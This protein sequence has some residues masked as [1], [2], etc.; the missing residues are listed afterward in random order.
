MCSA[1]GKLGLLSPHLHSSKYYTLQITV[2]I[3]ISSVFIILNNELFSPNVNV[4]AVIYRKLETIF[5]HENVINLKTRVCKELF[6]FQY[7]NSN[8]NINLKKGNR[9]ENL[10]RMNDYGHDNNEKE[11]NNGRFQSEQL[12]Y[13]IVQGIQ[14]CSYV[15]SHRR[16]KLDVINTK[17]GWK[18]TPS[19]QLPCECASH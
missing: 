11:I 5:R 14:G 15:T 6:F 2:R 1:C 4:L 8:H 13:L 17:V 16:T 7:T 19:C 3:S 9:V 10:L 18:T 12:R